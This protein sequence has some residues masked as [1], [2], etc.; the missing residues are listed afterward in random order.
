MTT[1][2]ISAEPMSNFENSENEPTTIFE[3]SQV[4]FYEAETD[5]DSKTNSEQPYTILETETITESETTSETKTTSEKEKN[6]EKGT[7]IE[8]TEEA[9]QTDT[10]LLSAFEEYGVTESNFNTEFLTSTDD[11]TWTETILPDYPE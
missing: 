9:A 3:S 2:Q 6:S 11:E 10:T 1:T 7:I 8:T 4:F 5:F